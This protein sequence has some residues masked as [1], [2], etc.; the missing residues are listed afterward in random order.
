MTRIVL[1]VIVMCL[2]VF[3]VN[4]RLIGPL[5]YGVS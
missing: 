1:R 4:L 3:Y 2:L 5:N